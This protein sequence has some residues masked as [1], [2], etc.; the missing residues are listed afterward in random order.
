MADRDADIPP[1]DV[2]DRCPAA[3]IGGVHAEKV[4]LLET[5]LQGKH[6]VGAVFV[7]TA[8]VRPKC[9]FAR[10]FL[11][12]D[13]VRMIRPARNPHRRAR[14][15]RVT[16]LEER[17]SGRVVIDRDD[18]FLLQA[19]RNTGQREAASASAVV[20]DVLA[21]L[22]RLI[23]I[24]NHRAAGRDRFGRPEIAERSFLAVESSDHAAVEQRIEFD[25]DVLR[26]DLRSARR[27]WKVY[28]RQS[29]K[30]RGCVL[31]HVKISSRGT[32]SII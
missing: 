32:D 2:R 18:H 31:F 24:P 29:Q 22:R 19:A 21:L 16:D 15:I 9:G 3:V 30:E 13:C 4:L 11:G 5:N 7:G 26:L 20:A 14:L 23:E 25:A 8:L 28:G 1:P 17:H 6:P 10:S 12:R 27:G